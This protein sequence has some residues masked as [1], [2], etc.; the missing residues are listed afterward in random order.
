MTIK[1]IYDADAAI[2]CN[3]QKAIMVTGDWATCRFCDGIRIWHFHHDDNLWH[4][5]DEQIF[6]NC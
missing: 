6:T 1:N 3:G 2:L 4:L 5:W